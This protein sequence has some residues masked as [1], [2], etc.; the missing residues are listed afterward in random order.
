LEYL[1][2]DYN[3][4]VGD[5]LADT[6]Y[7][8]NDLNCVCTIQS[9]DSVLIETGEY[10]TRWNLGP[11]PCSGEFIEG[12]GTNK[13]IFQSFAFFESNSNFICY[14]ENYESYYPVGSDCDPT[15][16]IKENKSAGLKI[17]PNPA[18]EIINL[19]M[20]NQ[21]S[22][23]YTCSLINSIGRIVYSMSTDFSTNFSINSQKFAK[24]VYTLVV[25]SD[26]E[27]ISSQKIIIYH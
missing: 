4:Q 27:Y 5:T 25:K 21:E 7:I 20:E 15:V 6:A 22:I 19:K 9:I 11:E 1:L 16:Q 13:G 14:S 12:I 10:L 8:L 23:N 17:F 2:F 3:L 26:K 18:N 24:G